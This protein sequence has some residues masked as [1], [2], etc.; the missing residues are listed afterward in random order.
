MARADRRMLAAGLIAV[1][2]AAASAPATGQAAPSPHPRSATRQVTISAVG[3]TILGN[4]PQV[5]AHP[6]HYFHDVR[7]SL[8][9]GVDVVFA[10][11]EGTLTT[12]SDSKCGSSNGGTC[13][14]FRNPPSFARTF[15]RVGFTVLNNANNHAHDFGSAGLRQTRHAIAAAGMQHAGMPGEI[16]Y[17]RVSGIRTAVLG[18]APYSNTSNMLHVD[19]AARL[20]HDAAQHSGVVIVYM[21]AG[22]EGSDRQH[23]TGNEEYY[24]GEDRGNP[25]HF[26]HRMIRAGAD[27]VLGS[28]PHVLRGMEFY[29]HRLIAY[30]LGNFAS[31]H[32]FNTSGVLENSAILRVT[33]GPHGGF[34]SARLVGVRLV[35]PGRP[36]LQPDSV[37]MVR[38]LSKDDF[39]DSAPRISSKGRIRPRT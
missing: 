34:G 15:A 6:R 5:P 23:V 1:G 38:R 36:E 29:R 12:E 3:D 20:V 8:T 26:A 25:K 33:L 30:S 13:F 17:R 16:T 24:L 18:F 21:H 22:A 14:A 9:N 7:G 11:L 35:G 37:S 19:A 27:L 39:G 31:Y 32:N 10:N 4:T 28:G 2:V